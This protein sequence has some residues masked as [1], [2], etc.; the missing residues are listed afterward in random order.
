MGETKFIIKAFSHFSDG[1]SMFDLNDPDE[2]RVY[3]YLKANPKKSKRNVVLATHYDLFSYLKENGSD[4][5]KDYQIV[6][7]DFTYWM[8]N[9]S[10]VVNRPFDFY[11][12]ISMLEQLAYFY[13]NESMQKQSNE[14]NEIVSASNIYFAA[15]CMAMNKVFK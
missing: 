12:F 5:L 9:L 4:D 13:E 15:L 14:I 3:N 6:F 8:G 1:V 2:Y 10:R 7:F 11:H